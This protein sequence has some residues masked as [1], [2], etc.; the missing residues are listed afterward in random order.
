MDPSHRWLFKEGPRRRQ[1]VIEAL[2]EGREWGAIL[3]GFA[4]VSD[5]SNGLDL[6]GIDLSGLDLRKARLERA[7]LERA[8]LSNC[9]LDG[10]SLKYANLR[11]SVLSG[12]E[13]RE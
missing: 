8:N 4:G 11:E 2:V 1:Q 7:H 13:M 5:V 10:L 6:R 3:G 9:R 12:A